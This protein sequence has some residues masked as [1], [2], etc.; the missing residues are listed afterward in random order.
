MPNDGDSPMIQHWNPRRH[1]AGFSVGILCIDSH[2]PLIPGNMQHAASYS[3]APL[4]GVVRGVDPARLFAGDAALAMPIVAAARELVDQGARALVGACGSFAHFQA[5]VRAAVE[6][7]VCL[8]VLVQVPFLVS[9]LPETQRLLVYFAARRAYTPALQAACGITAAIH[10]RLVVEEAWSLPAFAAML[11]RQPRLDASALE[12]QVTRH[13]AEVVERDPDIGGI[14]LQ[15][16]DLPP[17]SA[18]IQR[19]TGRPVYDGVLVAEW[20]RSA[21]ERRPY[22]PSER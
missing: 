2:H 12:A 13:L 22:V 11:D 6:V 8:S 14:V 18:A 20:L 21:V 9:L 19:A 16:S 3:F 15:C 7:P 10:D 1:M 17:F 4:Y 5:Q